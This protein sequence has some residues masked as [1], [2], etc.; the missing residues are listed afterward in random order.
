M[1]EREK[2]TKDEKQNIEYYVRKKKERMINKKK[3][4]E[5]ETERQ[6]QRDRSRER[7]R[8]RKKETE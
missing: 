7:Q 1:K 6:R 8:E 5:R 4:T 3:N 2:D